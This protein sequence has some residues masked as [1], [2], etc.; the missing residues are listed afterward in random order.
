MESLKQINLKK[1]DCLELMKKIPDGSVDLVLTDPPYGTT[2]CKWDRVIPFE[3]MWEQL[4]RIIKP[5]GAIC[6]FGSEPFSSA[7]RMSNIKHFKYDWI[8]E[9]TK[10]SGHLNAKIMPLKAHET[11]SVFSKEKCVYYPQGLKPISKIQKKKDTTTTTGNGYSSYGKHNKTT[12]QSIGGYPRSVLKFSKPSKTLHPTQKP[13]ALLEY[14]IRTYTND[15]ETVLDF[16]MGSGSTG[17]ACVN[18]GRNFIGIELDD[19][20]FSVAK[21]RIEKAQ[22]NETD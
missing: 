11:I 22:K 3:P 7:L 18:T 5:N 15:G 1:G 16:T 20:Y 9:K 2:A 8:W 19:H 21:E 13:I 14:L 4:N 6:L 17:V 12:T 10:A